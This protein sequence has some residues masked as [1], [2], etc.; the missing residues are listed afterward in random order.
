VGKSIPLSRE[1]FTNRATRLAGVKQAGPS[2]VGEIGEFHQRY[3][4]KQ[5]QLLTRQLGHERQLAALVEDAYGLDQE[6]RALLR[7]TRPVR[8]PLDVL[9]AKIRGGA[10]APV[11]QPAEE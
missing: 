3:R 2:L 8:D 10:E 7:A 11:G 6:E 5:I 1:T 9:E 4:S